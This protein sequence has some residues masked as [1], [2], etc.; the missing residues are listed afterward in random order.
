MSALAVDFIHRR[1]LPLNRDVLLRTTLEHT[2]DSMVCQLIIG[3]Q[4]WTGWS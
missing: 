3:Q 4:G 2:L 1:K